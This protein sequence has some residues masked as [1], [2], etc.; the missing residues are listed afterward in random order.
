MR[1]ERARRMMSAR[2]DGHLDRT[3]ITRLRDH[4]ASCGVCRAEWQKM[5]ALDQLFRSAPIRDAPPNLHVRVTSRIERRDQLQR[6]IVG[7]VALT[8]GAAT[9]ALLALV[10]F[11]LNLLGNLGIGPALLMGG[12]ETVTQVLAFFDALSRMLLTLLDQFALPLAILG[13]GG[14]L[15]A[16][17]LNGLWIVAMRRLHVQRR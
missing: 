7:G 17:V 5:E 2:L 12:L 1:C 14:L 4:L 9:L 6:A 10:P 16:L 11:A 15:L 3:E 8:T 13:V